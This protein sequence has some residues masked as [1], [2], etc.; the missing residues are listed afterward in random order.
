MAARVAGEFSESIKV[1]S[2][3]KGFS[4]NACHGIR[5]A[6]SRSANTG[7]TVFKFLL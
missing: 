5:F 4:L 3:F 7:G 6:M 1:G 2:Y